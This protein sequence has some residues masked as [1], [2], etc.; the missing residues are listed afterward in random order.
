LGHHGRKL[1]GEVKETSGAFS[2]EEY[3]RRIARVRQVMAEDGWDL[4]ALVIT[5]PE[6]IYYLIGLNHQGYFAFTMLFLPREGGPTL[7]TRRMESYTISQ[8]APHIDHIGYGDDEDAGSAAVS[9]LRGL[10]VSS[11]RVGV[12]RSSMFLPAGVWEEM[13]LGLGGVEWVDT[14]RSPSTAERYRAGIVDEV[15]LVKSPDEIAYIRRAAAISDRAVSA[16]IRTAGVGVNEMEIAAVVYREMIL[17]GGEYPG[18]VPLIRSSETLMEEHSTWRDRYLEPGDR[19]FMELSGAMARYHA[20]LTRMGYIGEVEPGAEVA[21]ELARSAFDAV[22]SALRPGVPTGTVYD[23]WQG[24]V[25]EGLGHDSLVRHHCGYSVGIG[26]PPSWVGSSTVLGIRRNGL[27]E[28]KAGMVFH[29]LSWIT[30]SEI[31]DHFV[32]DTAVV[33]EDRAEVITTTPHPLLLG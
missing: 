11:G 22:V 27:V 16:G 26:F 20:P 15:R 14:S 30:D 13:E 23:A 17:G 18:F 25:D 1:L 8:Q 21:L 31:G 29:V 33:G 4:D 2:A 7:L 10:G 5:S 3:S 24:V 32:S 28:V 19:L 6:N 12:D 9:A